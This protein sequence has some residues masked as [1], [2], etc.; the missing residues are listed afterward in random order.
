VGKF[1]L[2]ECRA[3]PLQVFPPGPYRLEI[4]VTDKIAGKTIT[5]NVGFTVE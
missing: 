3:W 1:L 4:K 5:Q 2:F